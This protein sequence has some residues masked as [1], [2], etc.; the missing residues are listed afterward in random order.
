MAG[1][2]V[3]HPPLNG[4][5]LDILRNAPLPPN[6]DRLKLATQINVGG[7]GGQLHPDR[8]LK[9]IEWSKKLDTATAAKWA[10][11]PWLGHRVSQYTNMYQAGAWYSSYEYGDIWNIGDDDTLE[12]KGTY[13]VFGA[14]RD[15]YR[16]LGSAKSVLGYPLSDETVCD[17]G[18]G[19]AGRFNSFQKGSIYWSAFTGA[20]E[21]YGDILVYWASVG[22]QKSWLGFP[23]T[24]EIDITGGRMNSFQNGQIT[25]RATDRHIE[26]VSYIDKITRKYQSMGGI[27]SV[28]GLPANGEL[29]VAR[30]GDSFSAK[31]R[32]GSISVF[33][34]SPDAQGF[35]TSEIQVWWRGLECQ[36]RQEGE[37]ELAGGV[38]LYIPATQ[39]NTVNAFPSAKEPWKLGHDHQRI[40]GTNALLYSGP[41]AELIITTQLVELDKNV[42]N[43]QAVTQTLKTEL[44]N[45]PS[46]ANNVS[47]PLGNSVADVIA[48]EQ[49]IPRELWRSAEVSEYWKYVHHLRDILD[50]RDDRYKT[51]FLQLRATDLAQRSN[52]VRNVL[53][54][55]GDPTS[56]VWTDKVVV[57]GI[58]GGNDLGVYA[59]YFEV[60]VINQAVF[61]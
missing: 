14:I 55:P 13:L 19:L 60:K 39:G 24:G 53:Q 34:N 35:K 59:F 57:T 49:L 50:H 58:D 44:N 17:D 7:L 42:N 22:A 10:A 11:N 31:F 32:A 6:T 54:V 25:W 27:A 9:L 29:S 36:V 56:V 40:M 43:P 33:F 1:I 45:L 2:S 23:L 48:R 3:I 38:S 47:A 20:H 61:L 52:T 18:K 26:S 37:D 46:I 8:I 12:L 21:V 41:P 28:L 4:T 51:G 16:Q 5:V 30:A 15:R